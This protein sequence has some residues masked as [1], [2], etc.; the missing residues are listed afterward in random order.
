MKR[1]QRASQWKLLAL[2]LVV[3]AVVAACGGAEQTASS[4]T[5]VEEVAQA[6]AT[7]TNLP[8]V[9]PE[10]TPQQP[11]DTPAP[12]AAEVASATATALPSTDTPIPP[13]DTPEPA[14]EVTSTFGQTEDGLYFRGNPAAAVTVI[15]YS[16]FL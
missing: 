3:S 8:T 1:D 6:V 9:A 5:P 4:A 15:D 2:L 14:P 12:A 10:D 16:D 13:T 11:T 7:A